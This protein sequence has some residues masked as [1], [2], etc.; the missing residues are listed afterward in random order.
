MSAIV[1]DIARHSDKNEQVKLA[2][3]I[4]ESLRLVSEL[5]AVPIYVHQ[6]ERFAQH[7]TGTLLRV[8]SRSF[9][10]TAAH[11]VNDA[12]DL[13]LPLYVVDCQVGAKF[14][15]LRGN[16]VFV[17]EGRFDIAVVELTPQVIDS[18]PARKFLRL[19]DMDFQDHIRD[20]LFFLFGFP[21]EWNPASST[22][23]P[24][25]PR[26]LGYV[27]RTY[28]GPLNNSSY[29]PRFH[30]LLSASKTSSR[31]IDESEGALPRKLSGIS[32]AVIWKTY[33]ERQSAAHWK[34]DAAK[35]VAIETMAYGNT[36]EIIRGTHVAGLTRVL[37]DAYTDLRP[38]LRLYLP[39]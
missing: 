17:R 3:V 9:L 22:T 36:H 27:T 14:H 35:I 26:Y 28:N 37:H 16:R 24:I 6:E 19:A 5:C 18:L 39:N 20:G 29:D 10:L 2:G 33:S 15:R 13:E 12:D 25:A 30:L 11:V 21:C 1:S 23:G 38:V 8:D 31:P 32:G 4:A 7:G 34:P